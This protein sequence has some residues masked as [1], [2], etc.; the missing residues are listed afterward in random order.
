MKEKNDEESI[1]V[2][3]SVRTIAVN[4]LPFEILLNLSLVDEPYK[5]QYGMMWIVTLQSFQNDDMGLPQEDEKAKLMKLFQEV[6]QQVMKD[7]EIKIIGT[8][9][10]KGVY[11]IMF[12]AKEEDLRD[13]GGKIAEFPEYLEDQ[14]GR[15]N[16][17]S[18][19]PDPNWEKF[20]AFLQVYL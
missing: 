9:L 8:T 15:F 14:N 4:D 3:F 2:N 11:D 13:I 12:Y 17:F 5:E 18:G 10:H 16:N 1:A 19:K 20:N 7:F 6:I